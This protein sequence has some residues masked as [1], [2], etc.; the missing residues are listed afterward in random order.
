[1]RGT[2]FH[3]PMIDIVQCWDDGVEDDIRLCD[4]LRAHGAKAT[5]NLCAGLHGAIRQDV[6]IYRE[7]KTVKRLA[8]CELLDVY[9]GFVIANHTLRHSRSL[10]LSPQQWRMEVFDGRKHLQ[11]IFCQAVEGFVYPFGER[12]ASTDAIVLEAGH[13]YARGTRPAAP[14]EKTGYP[15]ANPFRLVPDAHFRDPDIRKK[16]QAAKDARKPVFYFW[17]HSY[18]MVSEEEWQSLGSFLRD[19]SADDAC[20]WADVC[21]LFPHRSRARSAEIRPS[22][23]S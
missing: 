6:R 15:C 21:D 18:E 11:D 4:M 7:V 3:R 12:D 13:T 5:F 1:M 9:D 16:L 17:G 19:I 23:L 8:R 20:R 14:E 10:S 2:F 22:S